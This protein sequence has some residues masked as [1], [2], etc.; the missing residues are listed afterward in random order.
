MVYHMI[1]PRNNSSPG[2]LVFD[3]VLGS[4]TTM[5]FYWE[6]VGCKLW[7]P[8]ISS[9]TESADSEDGFVLE[10]ERLEEFAKELVKLEEYWTQQSI[11]PD[12]RKNILDLPEDFLSNLNS[13]KIATEL[14]ISRDLK[15]MIA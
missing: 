12:P 4:A 7:L 9:L 6:A 11:A 14:A 5:Y 8:I 15:I 13:I 1:I 10:G 2:D 3:H